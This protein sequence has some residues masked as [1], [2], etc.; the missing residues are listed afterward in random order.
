MEH[1]RNVKS[2]TNH[3]TSTLENGSRSFRRLSS[4]YLDW[5]EDIDGKQD[6][7]STI[8]KGDVYGLR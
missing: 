1:K 5:D 3:G 7:L 4:F 6:E 2:L 8:F